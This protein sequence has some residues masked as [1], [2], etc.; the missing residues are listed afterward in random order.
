MHKLHQ[1]LFILWFIILSLVSVKILCE[2]PITCSTLDS[3]VDCVCD[4]MAS[5]S[6]LLIQK[7]LSGGVA[8]ARVQL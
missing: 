8:S 5:S 4:A 1:K 2:Q 6:N 3:I 7:V